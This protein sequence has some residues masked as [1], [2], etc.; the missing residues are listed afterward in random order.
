M[1]SAGQEDAFMDNE[2]GY[3]VRYGVMGHVGKF[4][5]LPDSDL[6]LARGQAVVIQTDRGMELGE[7][8][9]QMPA[10]SAQAS[11]DPE[12]PYPEE[13]AGRADVGFGTTPRV[14]RPAGPDDMASTRRSEDLRGERF[15]LCSQILSE[16]GWPIELIDVEILLDPNTA[17]LHYVG[18]EDIDL[19]LLRARFR[20]RCAFDVLL[21][22]VG[23]NVIS[24]EP[25]PVRLAA[26]GGCGNCGSPGGC[27][28]CSA[29][30]PLASADA[31]RAEPESSE[32]C[33]SKGHS[34]CA[35]C[36]VAKW[37]LAGHH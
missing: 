13:S 3:L 24:A 8:L 7:V 25:E 22:P 31:R 15:V 35:S 5:A 23:A 34:A 9:L 21:E 33:T 14:I 4:R 17:V 19:S 20:S 28:S 30:S 10:A 6:A 36:G 1:D 29:S 12:D 18:P 27:G 16:H 26:G 11:R 2:R 32:S 37:R